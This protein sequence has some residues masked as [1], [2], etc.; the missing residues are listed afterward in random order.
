MVQALHARVTFALVIPAYNRAHLIGE[1]IESA[2]AQRTPFSEIIV[3][4]DGSTDNTLEVLETYRDRITIIGTKNN[5]VQ[6]ARNTGIRAATSD[7]VTLCDS[8]DLLEPDFLDIFSTWLGAHPQ[9]DVL[10]SNFVSFNQKTVFGDRFSSSPAGLYDDVVFR[11]DM[12]MYIDGLVPR[13][14]QFQ[15]LF[16]TGLTIRR[17]KFDEIG[18]YDVRFNRVGAED[19]EFTLRAVVRA[20]VGFCRMPLARVRRHDGNDSADQVR[21]I[22]GEIQIMEYAL[23]HHQ[24]ILAYRA[25]FDAGM[26]ERCAYVF[27][28]AFARGEFALASRMLKK[29]RQQPQGRRFTIKKVILNMPSMLRLVMWR[30]TQAR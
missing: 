17:D 28:A 16:V 1:T 19:F 22:D 8:D 20:Q 4:D 21:H 9:C 6:S 25:A 2:L 18:H 27:D 12:A 7:Y 15:I 5:G 3:V 30:L 11:E 13:I 24:G 10:Y 26:D 23:E 14:L 29:F